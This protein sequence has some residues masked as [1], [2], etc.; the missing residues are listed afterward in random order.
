MD[1]RRTRTEVEHCCRLSL[2]GNRRLIY[3]SESLDDNQ[4][5]P[6][7]YP[8]DEEE[9]EEES[10]RSSRSTL[11]ITMM[12]CVDHSTQTDYSPPNVKCCLCSCLQLMSQ[13]LEAQ[14]DR[15]Q[16]QVTFIYFLS[17]LRLV[18]V[19]EDHFS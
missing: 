19:V 9:E 5:V 10:N 16:F 17:L 1:T 8:M 7:N 2:R 6:R 4:H 13:Q 12:E 14:R 3:N 15:I 18:S 11:E